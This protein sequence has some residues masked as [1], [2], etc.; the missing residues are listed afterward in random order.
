MTKLEGRCGFFTP[1]VWMFIQ[2][3]EKLRQYLYSQATLETLIQFEYSAF[4]EA[5]VPVCTFTFA[6]HHV[7]K[8]GNYLRLVD[9]RGGMEVQR[10]KTLEAIANHNCGFYYE[11]SAENF[12]KIPGSPV[13][14]WV[15]DAFLQAFT[16]KK[17]GDFALARNGMKTGDNGK[18]VRLWWEPQENKLCLYA[19][20]ASEAVKSGKKW[21]PYNKGGEYRKWY[22]NNEYIVDWER[23]GQVVIGNAK[24]E[25]RNVQ[26]YPLELK[27]KPLVTWSLITSSQ[28]S[29]R[30]KVSCICDIAGMS[31]WSRK[32]NEDLYY[33]LALCNTK[34]TYA[35]LKMIAPTINFQA[36]DISRIPVIINEQE[37]VGL[38][39]K[40][41]IRIS[42][43]DWDSYE[44][45]WDF[46]K[47]P[48]V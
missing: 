32:Q 5:T 25:K 3:Y 28:P 36:G 1:Y 46:K 45:S 39:C 40:S 43:I 2:S 35:V 7:N 13:A 34:V 26:D 21:F 15:S 18:F 27:F 4:E 17:I 42:N 24:I 20:D 48:L 31:L 16:E 9:F 22:G 11:Q 10:Q 47:H 38:L 8:K 37:K 6:K 23:E 41:N 30:Y 33:I 44:T 29:F 14:Y 19:K 12:A